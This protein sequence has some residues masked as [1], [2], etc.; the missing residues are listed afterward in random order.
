MRTFT[1]T[2]HKTIFATVCCCVLFITALQF[3]IS[4]HLGDLLDNGSKNDLFNGTIGLDGNDAAYINMLSS[5]STSTSAIPPDYNASFDHPGWRC[6]D[7]STSTSTSTSNTSSSFDKLIFVHVFK[8]AGSTFR[9]FFERYGEQCG[10]GVSV[11]IRCSNLSSASL[12]SSRSNPDEIWKPDCTVKKTLTRDKRIINEQGNVTWSHLQNHSDIVIGHFPL[13]IH[14]HWIDAGSGSS[15]GSSSQEPIKPQY[16]TFFRDP[17]AQFVSA[18]LYWN[19]HL[20]W[21]FDEAVEAIK[22][23][24]W[25]HKN[26]GEYINFY[27]SYLTTPEQKEDDVEHNYS[28]QQWVHL[29]QQNIISMHVVV[30]LVEEMSESLELIQS[31]IDVDRELKETFRKI[32]DKNLKGSKSSQKLVRNKSKLETSDIITT[33]KED[34]EFWNMLTDLVKYE[35]QLYEF[36]K[37]VHS[38]QYRQLKK[39]HGRRYNLYPE[40]QKL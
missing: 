12:R 10:R 14:E 34:E 24:A 21:S 3:I 15:S 18:Q 7:D 36:A 6:S 23:K 13:G 9:D 19:T 2:E 22:R 1:W 29:I 11:I 33:L 40:G 4:R 39:N 38:R 26:K 30:G 25:K 8:T 28:D 20:D 37:E 17:F 16:I 5:T 35:T 31:I 27:K 32:D